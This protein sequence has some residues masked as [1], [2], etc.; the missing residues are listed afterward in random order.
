MGSLTE[1]QQGISDFIVK[2]CLI[3]QQK[4]AGTREKMRRERNF[5]FLN[6]SLLQNLLVAPGTLAPY[7]VHG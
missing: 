3:F 7:H 2:K 5:E 1:T 4:S 6:P